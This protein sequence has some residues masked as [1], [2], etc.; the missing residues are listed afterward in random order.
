MFYPEGPTLNGGRRTI[1]VA[2]F[3]KQ[4]YGEARE[5]TKI[6]HLIFSTLFRFSFPSSSPSE[7]FHIQY[8]EA[9]GRDFISPLTWQ[10][11][12]TLSAI[13]S[14]HFTLGGKTVDD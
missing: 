13:F 10:V 9:L 7:T 4:G 14:S 1:D 11:L 2:F 6:A 8:T 3:I 12:P 5:G